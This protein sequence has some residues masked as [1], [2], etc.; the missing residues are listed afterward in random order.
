MKL[1]PSLRLI[2]MSKPQ[3][4]RA[5]ALRHLQLVLQLLQAV[6][7]HGMFAATSSATVYMYA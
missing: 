5:L 3:L 7:L 4:G 1:I 2:S 6:A